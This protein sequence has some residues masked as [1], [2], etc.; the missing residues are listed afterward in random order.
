MNAADDEVGADDGRGF[1]L[2]S[3]RDPLELQLLEH[4]PDPL[5]VHAGGRVVYVNPAGVEA[6]ADAAP[7]RS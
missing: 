2:A 1:T 5:C 4:S 3:P 7:T 6:I